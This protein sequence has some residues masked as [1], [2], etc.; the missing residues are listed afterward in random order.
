MGR[1][2]V[3]ALREEGR[4][5]L[6]V[7]R[8]REG[9]ASSCVVDITDAAA[10]RALLEATSPDVV[11]HLAALAHRKRGATKGGE[12]NRVNHLGFRNVLRAAA[13]C[14]TRRMILASSSSV[15][16]DQPRTDALSELDELL[17]SSAY[18][19]SKR[20]AEAACLDPNIPPI[21]TVILRFPAIYSSEFLLNVRKRAYLPGFGQ[22][23]LVSV[24]GRQPLYSFC[25]I[26]HTVQAVRMGIDGRLA[27]GPY[28]VADAEPYEQ[29]EVADIVGTL[30][31]VRLRVPLPA[32][33][34]IRMANLARRAL[35]T[36][37]GNALVANINKMLVGLVVDTRKIR[38]AGFQPS[39]TM[40][41]MLSERGR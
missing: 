34:A 31:G 16:G 8:R 38:A 11:I 4:N 20:D 12:Y 33:P 28:N 39:H 22:R 10:V 24:R 17:P 23:V 30:D 32:M 3:A 1:H 37:I 7:G 9:A 35:S 2:L 15:Y 36:R 25:A 26:Q 40:Y 13:E 21:E 14:G 19:R 5:V 41:E 18:G 27:S 29:H 6:A